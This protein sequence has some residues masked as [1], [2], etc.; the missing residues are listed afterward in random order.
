MKQ[1]PI[2]DGINCSQLVLGSMMLS[3]E[4]LDNS[5]QIMDDF[6]SF[7]GNCIDTGHVYGRSSSRAIGVWLQQRKN[8]SQ[9]MIIGKGGHPDDEGNNRVTLEDIEQDLHDTFEWMQTNYVDIFMLHKDDPNQPVGY[10]MESLNKQLEAGYCRAIGVSN[11]TTERIHEANNYAQSHGL[12][13]LVC[14]SPNFSLAKPN[15]PRWAGCVH[16]DSQD[17]VWYESTQ[18]PVFSWSS[19]AG[20]FFT[21]RYNPHNGDSNMIRVYYSDD[22]WERNHRAETL[23]KIKGASANTIALG[24]VLNQSFPTCALIGP[25]SVEELRSSVQAIDIQLTVEEIHYLNL[26]KDI[27]LSM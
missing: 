6:V 7:G 14:S 12:Q 24:Y 18:L 3:E 13:G 15:E 9:I 8:R 25:H 4:K 26:E 16:I 10:I 5:I 1:I 20:G 21:G 22:N 19:Q 23:G 17:M 2:V 27:K 11:W